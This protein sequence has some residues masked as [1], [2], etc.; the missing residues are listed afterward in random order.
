[1][2]ASDAHPRYLVR[3]ARRPGDLFWTGTGWTPN[4]AEAR[5]YADPERASRTINRLNRRHLRRHHPKR[6]FLLTLVVRVHADETV[7]RSNIERYLRD[8]LVVGVDHGRCGTGPTPT[9][10][11]EVEVPPVISLEEG[12]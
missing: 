3:D 12:R 5:L 11:V 8:A 1:M 6:L 9:S 10:L 7:T 4:L 2:L